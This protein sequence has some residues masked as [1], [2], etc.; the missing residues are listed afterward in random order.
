MEEKEIL[1]QV[2][3]LFMQYGIKSMTMD[4]IA[5][6]LGISKKTLYQF[7]SNKNELVI[8]VMEA[9]LKEEKDCIYQMYQ[10][11]GNPIDELMEITSFVRSNMKEIHPS[12]LFDLKK[13]HPEAWKLMNDH[14]ENF[15]Y[16]SIMHNLQKGVEAGLYRDNLVPDIIAR[17]YLGMVN[18]IIDKEVFSAND[19]SQAD[20]H[21][22]M[23]R[24]HIRGIANEK[25]R[26]Y[27]KE[28]FSAN[29]L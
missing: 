19:Y 25:G 6:H 3:S 11:G 26:A 13:Y 1:D 8:K 21:E 15:I 24:Y 23:M 12:V 28:K 5:R 17:L 9:K 14:K 20:L 18:V 22:Q 27:L 4:E 7:V 16:N 29:N 2:V 10:S